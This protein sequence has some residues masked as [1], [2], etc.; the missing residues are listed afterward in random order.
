MTALHVA[1]EKGNAEIVRLLLSHPK[2]D[3]NFQS[4]HNF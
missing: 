2:I 3:I 4:I 1:A